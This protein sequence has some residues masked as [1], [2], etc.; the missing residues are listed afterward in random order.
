[1]SVVVNMLYF[2]DDIV[3]SHSEVVNLYLIRS[4]HNGV[5]S[6]PYRIALNHFMLASCSG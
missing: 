1:M 3:R 5:E 4:L 6:E 2:V